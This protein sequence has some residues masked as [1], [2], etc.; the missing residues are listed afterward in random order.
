MNLAAR[1]TGS[2]LV[3]GKTFLA[4][5][6]WTLSDTVYASNVTTVLY[7]N[8]VMKTLPISRTWPTPTLHL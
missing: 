8:V 7:F 2:K 3:M 6:A 4:S 1:F 5:L